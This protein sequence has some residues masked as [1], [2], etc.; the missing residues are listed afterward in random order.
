MKTKMILASSNPHKLREFRE[1]LEP[2]GCE[3]ISQRDAGIDCDPEENGETFLENSAIKARAIY[4]I[5]KVPV[6]ADDSGIEV[7]YL[8]GEP[9][10][11]SARYGGTRDDK[12]H[13]DL[14][15]EKLA[16]V[17]DEKRTARFVCAITYIDENGVMSQFL[18]KFEGRIGYKERGKNGFGYDPIFMVGDISSA[19]MTPDEK[20]AVSHR[21]KALRMLA[22]HIKNAKKDENNA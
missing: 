16:G 1:I 3:V 13:N 4:E 14:V 7:D 11:H 2:L 15:L 22:E 21:G 6:I 8:N 10:V 9:G 20:N 5:A 18:G 17:P 19:E 12:I